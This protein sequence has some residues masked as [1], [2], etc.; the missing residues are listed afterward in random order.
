M[1]TVDI[2]TSYDLW[3]TQHISGIPVMCQYCA[4]GILLVV[5]TFFNVLTEVVNV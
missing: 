2:F 4:Q 3:F 1:D 5:F